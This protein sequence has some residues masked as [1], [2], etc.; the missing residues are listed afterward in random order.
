M[1]KICVTLFMMA[2]LMVSLST[3]AQNNNK[4]SEG[5][6][7]KTEQADKKSGACCS[8]KKDK[9]CCSEKKACCQSGNKKG[10]AC[11]AGKDK[12]AKPSA[13]TNATTETKSCG[14][15]G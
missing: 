15:K 3:Y 8:E 9:A 6:K 4:E 1:K 10:K 2:A 7:A 5:S 13:S 14:K 11:C 12:S